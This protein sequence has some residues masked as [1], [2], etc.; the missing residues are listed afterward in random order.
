VVVPY[1]PAQHT[2]PLTP[3]HTP[4]SLASALRLQLS[5]KTAT[6]ASVTSLGVALLLTLLTQAAGPLLGL[7][8]LDCDL[9]CHPEEA[10]REAC[11][12]VACTP[13]AAEQAVVC[14]RVRRGLRW[15]ALAFLVAAFVFKLLGSPKTVGVRGQRR[16]QGVAA[17]G[18]RKGKG[19]SKRR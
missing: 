11:T 1:E 3:P 18:G 17:A 12:G 19:K 9:C 5:H 13:E 6:L 4:P 15:C 7:A 8:A 16:E 14:A 2:H 10:Q